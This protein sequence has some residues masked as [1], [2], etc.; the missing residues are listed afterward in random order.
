VPL[1]ALLSACSERAPSINPPVG[2]LNQ[3]ITPIHYA[4]DLTIDPSQERFSGTVTIDIRLQTAAKSLWLH[5]KDLNVTEVTITPEGS[6]LFKTLRG[7][8]AYVA[9]QLEPLGARQ[10]FPSFDEP[11]FKVPFDVSII[12]QANH[13]VVT[14]TP[15]TQQVA[16]PDG[17]IRH[18]FATTRPL[19]TYLLAFAVGP[20]DI[21]TAANLAPTSLRDRAVPLRA[22]AAKGLG[23]RLT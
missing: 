15:E 1:A 4:L 18:V 8:D 22:I 17:L 5:G 14:N 19:P 20:Y 11:A 13:V 3:A 10:I 12:A 16:L 6:A 23:P 2:R 9:S 7:N 21:N